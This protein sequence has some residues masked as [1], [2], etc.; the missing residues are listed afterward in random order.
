MPVV[1]FLLPAPQVIILLH[2]LSELLLLL[3]PPCPCHL[4]PWQGDRQEQP[5][6]EERQER[7]GEYE[8]KPS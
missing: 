4:V 5:A 7:E 2:P 3:S 8:K 6:W 1:L